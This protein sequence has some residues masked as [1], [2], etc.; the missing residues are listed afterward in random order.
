M[1]PA[2]VPSYWT[3]YFSVTDIDASFAKAIELGGKSL[4]APVKVGEM[5]SFAVVEDPAGATFSLLQPYGP[6]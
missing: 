3:D 6:A 4:V 1:V 5:L 2:Q